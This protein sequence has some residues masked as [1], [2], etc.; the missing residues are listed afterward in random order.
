M[1]EGMGETK[2]GILRGCLLRLGDSV[3]ADQILPPAHAMLLD[4]QEMGK[5]ALSGLGP[6]MPAKLVRHSVIWAGKNLGAGTGREAS[7]ICLRGAGVKVIVAQSVARLFFRNAIN[8]GILVLEIP[9]AD[10][11]TVEDG[12]EVEVDLEANTLRVCE[13]TLSFQP[14]PPLIRDLIACGGLLE[15]GRRLID[16]S[17]KYTTP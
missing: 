13:T 12:N 3:R 4:P 14:L 2:G 8:N 5:Y 15:Y 6:E 1:G 10:R 16:A 11:V 7:A 17:T 9:N